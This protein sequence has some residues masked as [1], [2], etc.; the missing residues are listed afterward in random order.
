MAEKFKS[1]GLDSQYG[2]PFKKKEK[3]KVDVKQILLSP[4]INE[5]H[6]IGRNVKNLERGQMNSDLKEVS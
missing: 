3:Q 1:K 2:I 4:L 6:I 5:T